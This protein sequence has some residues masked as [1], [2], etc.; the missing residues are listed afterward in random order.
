MRINESRIRRIIREEARRVLSEGT[1]SEEEIKRAAQETIDHQI[2]WEKD[3]RLDKMKKHMPVIKDYLERYKDEKFD[4]DGAHHIPW[5]ASDIARR[6]CISLQNDDLDL[7]VPTDD[8]R[9]ALRELEELI[10]N[11][12]PPLSRVE[13]EIEAF[14]L[15]GK[16][17]WE[18]ISND[19]HS[20]GKGHD[21]EMALEYYPT[22]DFPNDFREIAIALDKHFGI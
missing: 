3:K 16:G 15:D 9:A 8:L 22:Y 19:F 21:R 13:R 14:K 17:A 7:V 20:M 5:G 1:F 18:R 2:N 6:L 12:N 11:Y 4:G 10:R